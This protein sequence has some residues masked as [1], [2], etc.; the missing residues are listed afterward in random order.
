M[1]I[2]ILRD[3]L[4]PAPAAIL[5]F[6]NAQAGGKSQLRV[7]LERAL[8][9]GSYVYVSPLR[10]D[11]HESSCHAQ[12]WFGWLDGAV[13]VSSKAR[14]WRAQC[15]ALGLDRARIWVG[16]YGSWKQPFGTDDAFRAGPSFEARASIVEDQSLL[17][18]LLTAYET[19][20][21]AEISS[22][23]ERIQSGFDDGSRVLIRYALDV[24][25]TRVPLQH[26]LPVA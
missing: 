5:L 20:Y 26:C 15:V 17:Q 11:G 16:D 14:C 8:S 22:W 25:S 3:A 1:T 19:K 18:R 9:H 6:G 21:P 12:L 13:I 7:G 23:R 2:G 10:S 4:T 24:A